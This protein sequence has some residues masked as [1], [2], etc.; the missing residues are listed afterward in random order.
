MARGAA[1]AAPFRSLL[2][3]PLPEADRIPGLYLAC[4]KGDQLA[5]RARFPA[6]VACRTVHSLAFRARR[7]ADQR[8]RLE[9]SASGR[10]VAGLLAIPALDGLRPS[11]WGH[12]AIATVRGF[13]DDGAARAEEPHRKARIASCWR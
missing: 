4:N 6:H 8:H 13:T 10:D 5:A 12:G 3:R 11:F 1:G 9:R 7:M 2:R